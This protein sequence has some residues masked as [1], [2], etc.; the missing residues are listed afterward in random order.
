M[1]AC[2]TLFGEFERGLEGRYFSNRGPGGGARAALRDGAG[3]CHGSSRS[4]VSAAGVPRPGGRLPRGPRPRGA[5]GR[6]RHRRPRPPRSR[7]A[8]TASGDRSRGVCI[9]RPARAIARSVPLQAAARHG[10]HHRRPTS[11]EVDPAL[12]QTGARVGGTAAGAFLRS[13]R[14]LTCY[15]ACSLEVGVGYGENVRHPDARLS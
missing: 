4:R 11:H 8:R 14:R 5:R 12:G 15:G 10:C 2:E 9:A 6:D 13:G 3:H 1:I 7:G